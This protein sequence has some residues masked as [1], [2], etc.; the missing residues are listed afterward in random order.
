[1]LF[2][3]QI[4]KFYIFKY[5]KLFKIIQMCLFSGLNGNKF[6]LLTSLSLSLR[7]HLYRLPII[8]CYG[9][10]DSTKPSK[11]LIVAVVVYVWLCNGSHPQWMASVQWGIWESSSFP[12]KASLL[13]LCWFY[14][15]LD[16]VSTTDAF[17]LVSL[18]ILTWLMKF[19]STYLQE[20]ILT[21]IGLPWIEYG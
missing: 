3:N 13:F 15:C 20:N 8:I 21:L 19:T 7:F 16:P 14:S 5:S 6:T 12:L 11:E 2:C 18:Q 10:I 17:F 4:A 9:C 1:M